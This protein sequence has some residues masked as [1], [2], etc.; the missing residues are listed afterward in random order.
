[1]TDMIERAYLEEYNRG[2]LLVMLLKIIVIG[3]RHS[4]GIFHI[5]RFER[6]NMGQY[7]R[8]YPSGKRKTFICLIFSKVII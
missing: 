1:M 3:Q 2:N 6:R 4:T 7:I 8:L 5:F